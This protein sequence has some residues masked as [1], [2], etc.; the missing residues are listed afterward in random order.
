MKAVFQSEFDNARTTLTVE[1][2]L[3][4]LAGERCRIKY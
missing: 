4:K 3:Y 1:Q 2:E